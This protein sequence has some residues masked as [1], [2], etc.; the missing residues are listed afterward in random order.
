MQV[1]DVDAEN[2]TLRFLAHLSCVTLDRLLNVSVPNY[3]NC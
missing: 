3:C 2:L 1:R